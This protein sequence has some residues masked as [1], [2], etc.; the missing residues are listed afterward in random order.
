MKVVRL[1][2][3]PAGV[4]LAISMKLKNPAYDISVY[5]RNKLD[6][7]FWLGCRVF[8]PNDSEFAR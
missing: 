3:G 5:E 6:D 8:R 7:T 1:G 2:A 4:Y